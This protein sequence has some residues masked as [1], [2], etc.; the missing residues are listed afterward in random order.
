MNMPGVA[1]A[2]R[3]PMPIDAHKRERSHGVHVCEPA[4]LLRLAKRHRQQIAVDHR[5]GR[6]KLQP[7]VQL[8]VMHE[9]HARSIAAH[10]PRGD[11]EEA[12]HTTSYEALRVFHQETNTVGRHRTSRAPRARARS[13]RP[14][15]L[16]NADAMHPCQ[17]SEFARTSSRQSPRPPCPTPAPCAASPSC[18]PSG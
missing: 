10:H 9:Q 18:P 11:D 6:P 15:S 1:L 5:R 13:V 2:R 7:F 14:V 12:G 3:N 4:L 8:H 17:A 16:I